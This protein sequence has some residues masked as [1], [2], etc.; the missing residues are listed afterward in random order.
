MMPIQLPLA[1]LTL[2]MVMLLMPATVVAEEAETKFTCPMHPHYIADEMGSCP[3]CGM[4]LV[5]MESGPSLDLQADEA[6][7]DRALITIAPETIQNMGVRYGTP[8]ATLFGRRIRAYGIVAENERLRSEVSSRVAGWIESLAVTA[9]GDGVKRGTLLYRLFSPELV[10]AQRDY[11]SALERESTSRIQSAAIRLGALG[12][13]DSFITS[14]R[15]KGKVVER[16]PFYASAEGTLSELL[17]REGSYVRPGETLAV[18][19]DYNTVWINAAVAEKD[20]VAIDDATQVRV[21]L[22]NLPGRI[23]ETRVDYIHP[24]VDRS[25]RTGTVRL[26]LDNRDNLLRPGAYA[27]VLFEV[28]MDRRLAVPDSALLLAADGPY[29]VVALGE[30]RFQPRK[31]GTGLS[32]GGYTEVVEGIEGDERI[33]VSGQFLIDSESALR[34]SFQKLQRLK[35]ELVDLSLSKTQMAMLDHLIDAGLYLHEAL[36]DGYDVTPDQLQPAREIRN[37]LWS[38]FGQTRL[39]P[40]LEDAEQAIGEAQQARTESDLRSALHRLVS[41]LQPWLLDGRGDYYREKGVRLFK[42]ESD[43]RLWVQQGEQPYSPYS[44]QSGGVAVQ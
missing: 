9:V 10:A 22:P 29:L 19:Q 34:E 12:V 43:G 40:I 21:M 16:V 3:I 41:A 14:L 35:L 36:A 1:T 28:G 20:L 39:G 26:Q 38:K 32:S 11:L 23:I 13:S 5:K 44:D 2:L 15:K 37:M 8:Q 25:S 24:T 17:V 33:V 42:D 6:S 4:D 27:D 31:V 7:G 30:G 18:I